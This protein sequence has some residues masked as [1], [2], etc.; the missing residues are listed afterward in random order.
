MLFLVCKRQNRLRLSNEPEATAKKWQCWDLNPVQDLDFETLWELFTS[1]VL[2][3]YQELIWTNAYAF[4]G[5]L[6]VNWTLKEKNILTCWVESPCLGF[7]KVNGAPTKCEKCLLFPDALPRPSLLTWCVAEG[8]SWAQLCCP[9][10][11]QSVHGFQAHPPSRMCVLLVR[12]C[13]NEGLIFCMATRL[14]NSLPIQC[15]EH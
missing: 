12:L 13:C 10:I 5:D 14:G 8:H 6:W 9:S 4:Y 1:P 15:Q 11:E 3:L 2:A 7:W